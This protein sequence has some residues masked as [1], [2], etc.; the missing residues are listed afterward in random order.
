MFRFFIFIQPTLIY[1]PGWR[2]FFYVLEKKQQ[3]KIEVVFESLRKWW[4]SAGF[5]LGIAFA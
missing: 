5:A 3:F 2:V 1:L 4:E